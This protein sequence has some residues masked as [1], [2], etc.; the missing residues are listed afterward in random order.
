MSPMTIST[1]D[2]TTAASES[3]LKSCILP[4]TLWTPPIAT[5]AEGIYFYL[6]DGRKLVDAVGGAA[7]T[8]IGNGHPKVVKAVQ[9]QVAKVAYVYNAQLS[10]EPA[11]QLSRYLVDSSHGAF[12]ACGF[13][14]GGSEAVEA[15]IK[16]ARQY[17]YEISQPQRTKFIS[18][19]LSY[20]GNTL[21]ALQMSG[22]PSRRRPYEAILDRTNFHH[23]S[24]AYYRRFALEGESEEQYVERLARELEDK[25][26]E[27]GPDTVC[28]FVAETVVGATTGVV[29][30]PKG[31]FKAMKAICDKYGALLILDE[32]MCGM[33]RMGTLHAWESFGDGVHPDLQAV[34]KGLGGGYS[35]IGAVLMSKRIADAVRKGSGFWQH[36]H[37]YQ[38]VPVSC[39]A[40]LAVQ[41]VIKSENLLQNVL[42]A[43]ARLSAH[44]HTKLAA[45]SPAAPYV[46]DIRGGGLFWA[47]EFDSPTGE[48]GFGPLIQEIAFRNGLI[49]MGMGGGAAVDGSKG[50]HVILAPAYNVTEEEVDLIADL[51]VKSVEEA[52]KSSLLPNK[53]RL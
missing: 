33:G 7:V 3:S 11:E 31:Y 9:E 8:S 26:I 43:G 21:G 4:R 38:A 30:A 36:G 37:T 13:V 27:L 39:A 51:F 42:S 12:A 20:H 40:A 49:I 22:H 34:A 14:A 53:A 50:E 25:F 10:N 48:P 5:S 17:Y 29:P 2:A 6:Q 1:N 52:V 32:I 18:R 41:Q 16:L 19:K 24:P 46:A 45:P 28:A 23:V 44:L 47:V 35:P 15:T